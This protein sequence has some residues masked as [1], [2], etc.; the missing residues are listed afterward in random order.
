MLWPGFTAQL[1]SCP[2]P[3]PVLPWQLFTSRGLVSKILFGKLDLNKLDSLDKDL[4]K[5]MDDMKVC[6]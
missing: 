6:M 3:S 4:T 2:A 5:I 1:S